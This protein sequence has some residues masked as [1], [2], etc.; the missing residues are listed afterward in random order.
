MAD[1][2]RR[3]PEPRFSREELARRALALMDA[4]GTE[5]LTMRR[6]ANELGMA[7]MAVYRAARLP[8]LLIANAAPVGRAIR[9]RRSGSGEFAPDVRGQASSTRSAACGVSAVHP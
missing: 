5:A 2:R 4:H 1:R 3:G 9:Y 7:L 6:L 8:L